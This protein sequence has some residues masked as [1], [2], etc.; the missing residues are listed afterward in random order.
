LR[1]FFQVIRVEDTMQIECRKEDDVLV[2]KPLEETVD[3]NSAQDFKDHLTTIISEG[4]DLIVLD[5]EEIGFIDSS[6]LGVIISV[7]KSLE[8]DG[9]IVIAS[10]QESVD[11]LF[12]VTRTDK[13]FQMFETTEE[14]I[15]ALQK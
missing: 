10:A 4:N 2:V 12:K 15:A 14:A 5:T 3:S 13:L 8:G 1:V 7:L 9:E 11:Q 6:A